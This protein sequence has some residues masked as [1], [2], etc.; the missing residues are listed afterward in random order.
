MK[1]QS[2][3]AFFVRVA[4]VLLLIA[5]IVAGMLAAVNMITRDRIAENKVKEV[6][7][8]ISALFEC[9]VEKEDIEGNFDESVTDLW[10]IKSEGKE[11]GHCVRLGTKGYGGT[12]DMMVGFAPD[13]S[14]IG[15]QIV[16]ASSE[17]AGLGSRVAGE[18]FLSQFK[19]KSG[20]LAFGEGVDAISGSTVSSR[21]VLAGVNLARKTYEDAV[22]V[23]TNENEETEEEEVPQ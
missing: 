3:V 14:I 6:N 13:G 12:I 22:G 23:T 18:P 21:G 10:L 11:I 19:G 8:K 16:D 20:E 7:E 15:I 17:T 1:K 2:N 9:E 5:T 4:G